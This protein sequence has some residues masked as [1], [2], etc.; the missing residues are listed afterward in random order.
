VHP[1]GSNYT[2]F[3][4]LLGTQTA[5]RHPWYISVRLNKCP[6]GACWRNS[7]Q[8]TT[9][10]SFTRFPGHIQRR[11]TVGRTPLEEW[12][13]RRRDLCLTTHNITA[14]RH[15]HAPGG[16]RTDNLGRRAAANPRLSPCSHCDRHC[17]TSR[18]IIL[19]AAIYS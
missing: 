14:D 8:C 17:P 3:L 4:I 1:V 12:S 19:Q 15:I 11:T 5:D 2:N 13:A 9:A 18:P 6:N 10:F 16:I 7:P